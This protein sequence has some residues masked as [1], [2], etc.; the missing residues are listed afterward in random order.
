M[1]FSNTNLYSL[2]VFPLRRVL[3]PVFSRLLRVVPS[4]FLHISFYLWG[5][6]DA[7]RK[8]TQR[9]SRDDECFAYVTLGHVDDAFWSLHLR[10]IHVL[11]GHMSYYIRTLDTNITCNISTLV[12]LPTLVMVWPRFR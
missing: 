9:A 11:R 8:L 2:Y 1:S 5:I 12:V 4:V 7:L 3:H 6:S 10:F